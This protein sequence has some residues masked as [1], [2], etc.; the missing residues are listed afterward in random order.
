[1]EKPCKR[2]FMNMNINICTKW[3]QSGVTGMVKLSNS[4]VVAPG[5]GGRV[6]LG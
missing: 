6:E 4:E 3:I 5:G 1:M 2:G